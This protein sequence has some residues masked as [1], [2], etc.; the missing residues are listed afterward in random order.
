LGSGSHQPVLE[1]I[2]VQKLLNEE[3]ARR[4]AANPAYSLRALA[5]GLKLSP[6][7]LSLLL[8]GRRPATKKMAQKLTQALS[9]DPEQ[10]AQLLGLFELK[11][12]KRPSSHAKTL[13][14]KADEFH[15][16]ADWHCFAILSL[17]ETEG[18]K[19]TPAWIGRRLGIPSATAANAL[20]RMARL[21]LLKETASG[22]YALTH[23]SFS[24]SDEIASAAIKKNHAQVLELAKASLEQ[25]PLGLRDFL[26]ITLAID[27][28][29]I[30][31]AKI[32]MREFREKLGNYLESG[33]KKEVYA[34]NLQLIPLSRN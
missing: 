28:A 22:G 23:Q 34:L 18:A 17:L 11:K 10:A 2:A 20:A 14:L 3:F 9:L 31:E 26:S 6:A 7:G 4:K 32:L 1:T 25:D 15:L 19:S 27:P 29:K 12:A 33:A 8:N 16:V 30:P 21:G 13:R 5:K 24:T